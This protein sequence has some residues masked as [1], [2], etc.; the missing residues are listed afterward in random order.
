MG[1]DMTS[2]IRDYQ[3]GFNFGI[4]QP[5]GWYGCKHTVLMKAVTPPTVN[6]VKLSLGMVSR[7]IMEKNP[8]LSLR[9]REDLIITVGF[10]K[11]IFFRQPHNYEAPAGNS[12]QNR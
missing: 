8:V 3:Q 7:T 10:L 5:L 11:D 2:R 9:I 12:P 4:I 1:P 6:L